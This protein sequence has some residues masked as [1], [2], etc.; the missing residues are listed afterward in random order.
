MF[1]GWFIDG[2]K[3][4]DEVEFGY[5]MPK[6]NVTLEARLVYNPTNPEEP[7]GDGSQSGNI[8]KNAIGDLNGDGKIDTADAVLVINHFVAGTADKLNKGTADVTG[9]GKI[10]TAD[11][12]ELIN[13]YVNNTQ[14]D[15]K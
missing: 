13:R 4:S 11:A 12:V 8:S 2:Q 1:K 3:V 6:H 7:N 9:D 10:D 5:C 15:K 14:N